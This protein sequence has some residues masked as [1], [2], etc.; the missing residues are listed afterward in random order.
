MRRGLSAPASFFVANPLPILRLKSFTNAKI[1]A[2]SQKFLYSES[3]GNAENAE[4]SKRNRPRNNL[5]RFFA[6]WRRG[7][8]NPIYTLLNILRHNMFLLFV[9]NFIA[10]FEKVPK[11]LRTI[12]NIGFSEVCVN[13]VHCTEVGPPSNLCRNHLRDT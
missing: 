10:N 5:R 13:I 11:L 4:N 1:N 7:E 3:S 6:W 12:G 2:T 8:S 9:A